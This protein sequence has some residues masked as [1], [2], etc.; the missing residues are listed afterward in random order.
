MADILETGKIPKWIKRCDTCGSLIAYTKKDFKTIGYIDY[1]SCPVC[2]Q[3][4]MVNSN[5]DQPYEEYLEDGE[6]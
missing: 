2:Y 4:I 5:I 6:W 1:I 3:D